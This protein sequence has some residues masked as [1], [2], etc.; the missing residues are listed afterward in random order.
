MVITKIELENFK[1]FKRQELEFDPNLNFFIGSNASGKTTLLDAIAKSLYQLTKNFAKVNTKSSIEV[2]STSDNDI[3]YNHTSSVIRTSIRLPDSDEIFSFPIEIGKRSQEEINS[4]SKN[5]N[6]LIRK[7]E[8]EVAEGVVTIPIIKYFPA[9][10]TSF[11]YASISDKI[12]ERSQLETW[13]NLYQDNLS[14]SRFLH[15]FFEHES[16]ELR[17]QRDENNF[18]IESPHLKFVRSSIENA[19][20]IIYEDTFKVK[21]GQTKRK[22]SSRLT[23]VLLIKKVN[24]SIEEE[25][26]FKSDGEKAVISLVA[27]ISY[28]LSLA[29][30]YS[31][32]ENVSN[33]PGIVLI[34]QIEAH[35]HPNWQRKIIRILTTL[36]PKVQ[37]FITS[38]SPQVLS[39]VNSKNVF[40]CND[41]NIERIAFKSKG[42]DSNNLLKYLFNSSERPKIY[43]DF[44]N[45]FD[46]KIEE[47]A[48]I[49]E[50]ENLLEEIIS[51]EKEDEGNDIN[52]L[53]SELRLKLEAYKFEI[54]NEKHPQK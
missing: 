48:N 32:D 21:S 5:R 3:N 36:F 24:N 13:S 28:N 45:S 15:W 53:V 14:Y 12:Y 22:G 51:L 11:S 7:F 10:R 50:L 29:K 43:I 31:V 40:L 52:L 39:S 42:V 6:I 44:I 46:D 37:F 1:G 19:L 33:S 9:E 34:D 2:L 30:D 26:E 25:L 17:L 20:S 47:N 38:H 41:F 8:N 35:L 4:F 54:D 49:R 18:S 23:P 27:N 16:Q